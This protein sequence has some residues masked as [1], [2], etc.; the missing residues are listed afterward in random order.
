M[1]L[2]T[3]YTVYMFLV[4]IANCGIVAGPVGAAAGS[5][6]SCHAPGPIYIHGG[7]MNEYLYIYMGGSIIKIGGPLRNIV[8]NM[9]NHPTNIP[10]S[11]PI[12]SLTI[13]GDW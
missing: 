11:H 7:S 9:I 5:P 10:F 8:K 1:Y 6:A 12:N 13:L 4:S 2:H 3:V